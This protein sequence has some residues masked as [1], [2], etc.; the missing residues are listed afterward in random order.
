MEDVTR[1]EA[2]YA[3]ADQIP[4]DDFDFKEPVRRVEIMMGFLMPLWEWHCCT[5]SSRSYICQAMSMAF[6][7]HGAKLLDFVY[8]CWIS[9]FSIKYA[10]KDDVT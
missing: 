4:D 1:N 7:D 2:A 5:M 10:L 9:F 3:S 8:F 6:L